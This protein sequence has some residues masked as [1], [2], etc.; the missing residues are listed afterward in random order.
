MRTTVE[1]TQAEGEL[2]RAVGSAS[3]TGI[4]APMRSGLPGQLEVSYASASRFESEEH[5]PAG[6][7][8]T[9][10]ALLVTACSGPDDAVGPSPLD[11]PTPQITSVRVTPTAYMVAVGSTTEMT[12]V[13][14]ADSGVQY[15]VA[16]SLPAG[17]TAATIDAAT[18]ALTAVAPGFASP[19]ACATAR[20]QTVCGEANVRL[21]TTVTAGAAIR[22]LAFV[23]EGTVFLSP[24]NGSE[25]VALVAEAARPAWSPDGTRIAFTRPEEGVLADGN[26]VSPA[27]TGPTSGVQLEGPMVRCGVDPPGRLTVPWWRSV[28]GLDCPNGQ[29]GQFGGYYS[30]LSLLNTL[31]MQVRLSIPH[32][33]SAVSWSPDGDKIAVVRFGGGVF[34]ALAIVNPDGSGFEYLT[35]SLG[36]YSVTDVTWSP[37]ASRL[38]LTL[39]DE[40]V[41]PWY[42]DTAIGVLDADGT[43][44]RVLDRAQRPTTSTSGPRRGHLTVPTWRTRSAE[45]MGARTKRLLRQ[46]HHGRRSRR[47]ADRASHIRRQLPVLAAVRRV[48]RDQRDEVAL[49]AGAQPLTLTPSEPEAG[50]PGRAEPSAELVG[51]DS[52]GVLETRRGSRRCRKASPGRGARRR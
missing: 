27:R 22:G 16:W 50:G 49:E 2:T 28:S 38:A 36:S 15:T 11:P 42:C 45:G 29:C 21:V 44:L 41:C 18:G 31:T 35:N 1:V 51:L 10:L 25:P 3:S 40:S 12:V 39:W 7:P 9:L 30:G 4:G 8:G 37:D 14:L 46:R 6:H 19:R 52:A 43:Q 34:G 5:D 20:L 32:P 26:C 23:R 13:V 47:W 17:S 33:V 48:R 24:L